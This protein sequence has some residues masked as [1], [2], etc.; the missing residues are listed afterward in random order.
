MTRKTF[1]RISFFTYLLYTIAG[2][3]FGVYCFLNSI[4]PEGTTNDFGEGLGKAIM[5]ILGI[6]CFIYCAV[7][8]LPTFLKGLDLRFEKNVL[9]IFCI[10]FDLL[11]VAIHTIFVIEAINGN[12][13]S[14][15]GIVCGVLLATSILSMVSNIL[16]MKAK[17]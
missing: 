15:F 7:A 6:I 1:S 3:A 12:V 11:F 13:D 10:I 2:F 17:Y 5:L 8:I 9:T 16:C 14:P 4:T